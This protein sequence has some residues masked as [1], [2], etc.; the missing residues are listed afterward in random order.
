MSKYPTTPK[1][2]IYACAGSKCQKRGG[3]EI[4][5]EIRDQLKMAGLKDEV[6]IIKTEC[7]DRCKHGPIFCLQPQNLWLHDMTEHQILQILREQVL[8]K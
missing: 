6:E 1:Q 2:V 3:K 4:R 5:K 7:T 8:Q